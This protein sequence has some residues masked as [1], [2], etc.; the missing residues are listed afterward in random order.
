[1]RLPN[2]MIVKRGRLL[3]H[4]VQFQFQRKTSNSENKNATNKTKRNETKIKQ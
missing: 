3:E 2:E 4:H 1:M